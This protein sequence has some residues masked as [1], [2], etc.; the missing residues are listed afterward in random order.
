MGLTVGL[1][2]SGQLFHF[3]LQLSEKDCLD[4]HLDTCNTYP[5][6][7]ARFMWR[8]VKDQSGRFST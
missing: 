8:M 7:M 3:K 4:V 2:F 5:Y 6:F 1:L